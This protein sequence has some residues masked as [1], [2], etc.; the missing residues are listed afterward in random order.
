MRSTGSSASN[1]GADAH[2]RLGPALLLCGGALAFV[3][4][5]LL[6]RIPPDQP[7][8]GDVLRANVQLQS[9]MVIARD[10]ICAQGA[11]V[12]AA[13]HAYRN[14]PA[15]QYDQDFI[16]LRDRVQF[17]PDPSAWCRNDDSVLL[18][19]LHTG[20]NGNP[21]LA[22]SVRADASMSTLKPEELPAWCEAR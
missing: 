2:R 9:A 22:S 19:I 1:A 15:E 11:S 14:D 21:M 20:K 3:L 6:Q 17:N 4:F 7:L 16:L 10:R 8:M 13:A 12:P 5:A 18:V